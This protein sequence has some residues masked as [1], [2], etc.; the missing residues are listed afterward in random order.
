MNEEN[1]VYSPDI[2]TYSMEG[3]S[4]LFNTLLSFI[5]GPIRLVT[6][7]MHNIFVIP[8][9]LQYEY[10]KSLFTCSMILMVIGIIDFVVA[11][12]WPLAISQIVPLVYAV[13]LQRHA[14]HSTVK[15]KEKREVEIDVE[16]V[17]SLCSEVY[18]EI[19]SRMEEI[20]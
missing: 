17:E 11:R 19:E 14:K 12:K 8:A 4:G 20:K 18:G 5:V 2:K 13:R 6:R 3:T 1:K 15:A 10:A 9:D 16:Q 7:V